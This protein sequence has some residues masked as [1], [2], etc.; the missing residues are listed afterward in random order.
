MARRA[1]TNL[2]PGL[3]DALIESGAIVRHEGREMVANAA[4]FKALANVGNKLFSE[5][6]QFSS[7]AADYNPFLSENDQKPGAMAM[8]GRLVKENPD[9]AAL[10]IKAAGRQNDFSSFLSRR[11]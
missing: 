9:K 7:P 2:D 5:D 6:S 11:S 3:K 8:M 10:L 1:M 4:I